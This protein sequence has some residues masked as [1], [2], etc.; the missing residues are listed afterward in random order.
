MGNTKVTKKVSKDM[1]TLV[2]ESIYDELEDAV[3]H[4][5]KIIIDKYDNTLV[6]VVTDKHSKT[7]PNLYREDFINRLN[8]FKYIVPEGKSFKLHTPDLDNFDFSGKLKVLKTIMHGIVGVYVEMNEEDYK[9]VFN[10]SPLN[11]EPV[12]EYVSPKDRIYLIRYSPNVM[13][14]E[15]NL[16]KKFVRYPFSNTPPVDIFSVGEDL[17]TNH[18]NA[19]IEKGLEEAKKKFINNYKGA[20][21]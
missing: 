7:N 3:S 1:V 17:V 18:I 4:I 5:K 19:W 11:E 13:K 9:K 16:N 21:L 15:K 14:A 6:D 10:R 12:D 20:I 2:R 8:K